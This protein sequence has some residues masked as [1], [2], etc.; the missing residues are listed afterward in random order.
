MTETINYEVDSDGIATLTIDLPGRSMNVIDEAFLRDFADLI[1]KVASDDAVKGAIITSGKPAFVAGADLGMM[2]GMSGDAKDAPIEDVFE[3]SSNLNRLFRRMETCGKPIVAAVNGLAMGGG[4]EIVLACHYRIVAD[5]PKIQLST[6]EVLVGLLP[7]AGGTQRMPRLMGVQAALPYLS[8]GKS[9]SPQ[10]ALGLKMVQ[11]VVPA[12][13][14]LGAA[15]KWLMGSPDPVQPWDKKGFKVPGG[16]GGMDPR[17]VQTFVAGNGMLQKQTMHNYPAPQAIFSAVYEGHQV[18]IDAALRIES[19]YF[20]KLL[21]DPTSTNMIRSLFINK[22]AADKLARRPKDVE[23][24][25][26]KKLG[27]L[28]AG[29]MGAGVAYVSAKAGMDVVL[30]DSE[31]ENAEKGKQY[32]VGLVEKGVKRKKVSQE[33]GQALLDRI[34][35]STDYGDLTDCDLVI[36]AVFEN[37]NI[38]ADVT[39]KT[40]AAVPALPVF[41]SNTSTLPITGLAEAFSRQTDFIGIHFFSPVDRMPLVEI[42]MGEKT[43]DEALARSLDYVQQIGK[44]PIVVNDSR[45]FYTSRCFGT[46]VTEGVAMLA[47]GVVPALIENAGKFAGMPVGA[48]AVSDEVSIELGYKVREQTKKDLG[49]KYVG[50][51]GDEI[52]DKLM[53][54]GRVGRKGGKGYYDYPEGEKKHLWAGLAENWPAADEQPSLDE[55]KKRFLYR[56]AVEAARCL[57]EGVLRE[58]SDGDIG[59][60]LGWGY[61]PYTGGPFSLIDTVG[62]EEFVRECDRMAQ[63]YGARFAPPQLLRDMAEKGETFYGS[64]AAKQAA[65]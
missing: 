2:E 50:Q 22:Q 64:S 32:S 36:E 16:Q 10:E 42:I 59:A 52:V 35:P 17:I 40:E 3:Q 1:E 27:I 33:K 62:V 61:A 63:Q 37:R 39:K 54:L 8:Q 58:V 31:I 53:E 44:T 45:G 56:Q 26:V 20:T 23:K 48:L 57:E 29:M 19:R 9:M 34:K 7:G 14:L 49:D 60:I 11:E 12:D 6:P 21:L 28:G 65:E 51:P 41:A 18:P 25:Q 47:D 15:K 43:G 55:V 13:E 46:Y 24:T 4:L 38:K 5:N 30:I